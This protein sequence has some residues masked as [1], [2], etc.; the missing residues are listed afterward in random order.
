MIR[1][2]DVRRHRRVLVDAG[3]LVALL[4]PRDPAQRVC[5]SVASGII[6]PFLTCWPAL[7]EV[8][9]L[10]RRDLVAVQELIRLITSQQVEVLPLAADDLPN[11][12]RYLDR[13]ADRGLQLADA[14]LAHLAERERLDKLFTLDRRDFSG[15]ILGDGRTLALLPDAGG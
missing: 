5:R 1:R 10:L 9:Y 4:N 7:A 6:G 2:N 3:P 8:A 12:S 14:C 11:V 13:Y 15:L